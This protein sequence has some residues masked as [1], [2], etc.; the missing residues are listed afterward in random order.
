[1]KK[2]TK[3]DLINKLGMSE[4]RAKLIMKAQNEFPEL[5]TSEGEGFIID[6]RK[7]FEELR[8]NGTKTKFA[9]WIKTNLENT[10]MEDEKDFIGCFYIFLNFSI[11]LQIKIFQKIF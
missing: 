11:L 5:L 2:F 10:G 8:L 3:K 7:L 6:G 9:D 1:M 4:E